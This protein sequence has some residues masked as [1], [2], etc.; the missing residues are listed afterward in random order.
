[1]TIAIPD[2]QATANAMKVLAPA[3]DVV[4][5]GYTRRLTDIATTE[6]WAT[7][8]IKALA[9]ALKV[10]QGVRSHIAAVIA[11]GDIEA[12]NEAYTRQIEKL[13][14]ERRRILGL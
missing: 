14:P 10:S 11:G 2:P 12:A 13:S 9:F 4:E 6:P 5:A 1:M 3:F 8:K 7:D